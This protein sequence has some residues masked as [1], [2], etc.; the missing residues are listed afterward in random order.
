MSLNTSH[1][2]LKGKHNGI[3]AYT[4]SIE[5]RCK[6]QAG[7]TSVIVRRLSLLDDRSVEAELP[8]VLLRSGVAVLSSDVRLL[9]PSVL[10]RSVSEPDIGDRNDAVNFDTAGRGS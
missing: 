10:G 4:H 3:S 5:A 6:C 8:M 9:I 7:K 2:D 1:K